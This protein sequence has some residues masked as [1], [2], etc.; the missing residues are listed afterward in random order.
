MLSFCDLKLNPKSPEGSLVLDSPLRKDD[1][2]FDPEFGSFAEIIL[3]DELFKLSKTREFGLTVEDQLDVTEYR[4]FNL[5]YQDMQAIRDIVAKVIKLFQNF[6]EK[7]PKIDV[8][9]RD[10]NFGILAGPSLDS[11][12]EL[13]ILKYILPDVE[14]SFDA[15]AFVNQFKS[16]DEFDK[17]LLNELR[18]CPVQEVVGPHYVN[19]SEF[20][21]IPSYVVTIKL[22]VEATGDLKNQIASNLRFFENKWKTKSQRGI[23]SFA[24]WLANIATKQNRIASATDKYLARRIIARANVVENFPKEARSLGHLLI[25]AI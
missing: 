11:E 9:P 21:D 14:D 6:K 18:R 1:P 8:K 17:M 25:R 2:I 3:H 10:T 20:T 16:R 13:K 23:A 22:K 4:F 12:E 15:G 7:K 19:S 24:S 5:T